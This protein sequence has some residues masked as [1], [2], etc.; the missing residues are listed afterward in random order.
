M[1]ILILYN[2]QIFYKKNQEIIEVDHFDALP[3]KIWRVFY[4]NVININNIKIKYYTINKLVD[5]LS[6][7]NN[8]SIGMYTLHFDL[9]IKKKTISLSPLLSDNMSIFDYC[10]NYIYGNFLISEINIT[11][12]LYNLYK[13]RYIFVLLISLIYAILNYNL[14][15]IYIKKYRDNSHIIEKLLLQLNNI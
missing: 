3:D 11:V 1:D 14:Y 6:Y 7:S 4:Y 2:T 13:Y 8:Y 9:S 12:I 15:Y 10:Q 5:I